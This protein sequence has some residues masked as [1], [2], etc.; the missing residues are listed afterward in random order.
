MFENFS[1]LLKIIGLVD[2]VIYIKLV[3]VINVV[4]VINNLND[5]VNVGWKI[6]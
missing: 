4:M 3:D 1:Y 2:I 5:Y 6:V